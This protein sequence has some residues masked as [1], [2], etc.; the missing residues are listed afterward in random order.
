M[1]LAVE[2]GRT[3]AEPASPQAVADSV[4]RLRD[5]CTDALRRGWLRMA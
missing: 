1:S 3:A 4:G 5:D 2:A